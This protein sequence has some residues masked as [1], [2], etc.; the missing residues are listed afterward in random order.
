ML[1]ARER[2]G[3]GVNIIV[4]TNAV[5]YRSISIAQHRVR[6]DEAYSDDLRTEPRKIAYIFGQ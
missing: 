6:R 2:G 1:V 3:W 4:Y 5:G